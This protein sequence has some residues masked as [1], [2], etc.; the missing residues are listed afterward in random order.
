MGRN[1]A[2][3]VAQ[4]H[5]QE[6]G[7]EYDEVFAPVA[8]IEAIRLIAYF[9]SDYAGANLDRKSIMGG[10]QFLGSR[11]IFWQCKKQTIMTNSTTET[12]YIAA[13]NCC[14]QVTYALDDEN[15][16]EAMQEEL[17]QFKLLNVWTLV[18]LPPGKRA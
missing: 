16:I 14:G 4:G 9:N 18:D 8:R 10:C 1:K 3:L 17:L 11:L 5:R 7:I 15:W 2:R 6:E 12:E 13:S